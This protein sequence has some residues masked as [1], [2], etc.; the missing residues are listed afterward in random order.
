[1]KKQY[2]IHEKLDYYIKIKSWLQRQLKNVNYKI[3]KLG[4][5]AEVATSKGRKNKNNKQAA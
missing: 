5:G 3:V 4:V 2:S 1:M